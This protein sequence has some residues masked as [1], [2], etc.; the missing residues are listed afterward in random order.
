MPQLVFS[1]FWSPEE[2]SSK[3]SEG[4]DLSARLEQA[5]K[6]QKFPFYMSLY[7]L[8]VESMA[9]IKGKLYIFPPQDLD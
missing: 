2:V 8:P 9:Q 7:R 4:M 5:G 3:E 1:I 6:E